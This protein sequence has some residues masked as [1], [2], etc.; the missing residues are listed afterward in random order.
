MRKRS[1]AIEKRFGPPGMPKDMTPKPA[2]LRSHVMFC[3]A[4]FPQQGEVQEYSNAM[5]FDRPALAAAK[6]IDPHAGGGVAI[7]I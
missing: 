2:L 7:A 4:G 1:A 3:E 6:H 5:K